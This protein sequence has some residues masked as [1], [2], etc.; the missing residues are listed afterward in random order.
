MIKVESPYTP[1]STWF[2]CFPGST[3]KD[4]LTNF[5]GPVDGKEDELAL[6]ERTLQLFRTLYARGVRER[7]DL[8]A[9]GMAARVALRANPAVSEADLTAAA[10]AALDSAAVA[11]VAVMGR[12]TSRHRGR[13]L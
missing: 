6:A 8:K 3:S 11:S 2:V 12:R 9:A 4:R 1:R 10:L 7:E 5:R 13:R